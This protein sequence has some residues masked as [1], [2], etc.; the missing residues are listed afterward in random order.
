[1]SRVVDG[2]IVFSTFHAVKGR[3]RKH[4]FIVGFDQ[5]YFSHIARTADSD[6]CPNTLYV[7]T[8]RATHRLYLLEF[9]HH[10]TDRP[11]DFLKMGHHEMISSDFIRF[12][13][14]PRIVF[15]KPNE[16]EQSSQKII[17]KKYETPTGLIKF[18]SDAVMDHI[19]P[20]I[21]RIF[22][23]SQIKDSV[24]DENGELDIENIS[25]IL[26]IPTIIPTEHGFEDISDLNGIALP[27][28]YYDK[29]H[30]K[31]GKMDKPNVLYTMIENSLLEMKD[32]EHFFLK[33]VV[34]EIPK[35]CDTIDYYLF[36]ANV[37]TSIQ[38]RLYF[39]LKQ[40]QRKIGRA[41]D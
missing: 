34:K 33:N 19:S 41:H 28:M 4:V 29:I 8:T 11:L 31:W 10:A 39:K 12:K 22:T 5:S 26:D 17:E 6:V 27:A 20:I 35:V 24:C 13:G 15:Y 7:A 25:T 38:E 9:G 3:Q 32:S 21:D 36:L 37:Y 18:I 23:C 2:K 40:I 1:M 14:T 16:C 30:Q